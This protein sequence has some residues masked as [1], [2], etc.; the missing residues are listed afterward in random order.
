MDVQ[1]AQPVQSAQNIM[2][3]LPETIGNAVSS[4]RDSITNTV[5]EFSQNAAAPTDFNF[6]NTIIAKFAFLILVVIVFLFFLNLG[7][8]IIDYLTTY[9]SNP[10]LI[11]G[12]LD[13]NTSVIIPQDPNKKDSVYLLR[14]N[15]K[16]TGAE[17]TW[18]VWL[19]FTD[20]PTDANYH[21]IFNKGDTKFD[22]Y[23]IA[24]NNSP[25]L[26][27]GGNY[28]GVNGNLY[29][30][31]V[32]GVST[33]SNANNNVITVF[34]D[35]IDSSQ[36]VTIPI[37]NIPLQKWVNVIIRMENTILD[38]YVNGTITARQVLQSVPRQNYYDVNVG[39]MQGFPGKLSDLR[40][41]SYALNVFEIQTLLKRGPSSKASTLNV[42]AVAN[43]GFF[44]YLSSNWYTNRL[45]K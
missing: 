30:N 21:H 7:I 16:Q 43:N 31:S 19:Y 29:D 41:F 44:G 36:S 40:Y 23:N 18:S 4:V 34:M 22:K 28:N 24:I 2:N 9:S 32:P 35:T 27:Y 6:S 12:V 14:S 38:V 5:S 11:S 1:Q 25:G 42:D 39:Q 17:F 26:Y 3:K 15:N 10:Y 37:N 45:Y 13:G 8:N 20:I 33:K